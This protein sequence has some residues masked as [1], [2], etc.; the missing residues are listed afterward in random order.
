MALKSASDD[1]TQRDTG[2]A[3]ARGRFLAGFAQL[4]T[5]RETARHLDPILQAD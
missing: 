3:C 4:M 2:N 5:V 1:D